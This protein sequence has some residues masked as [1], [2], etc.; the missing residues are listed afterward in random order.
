MARNYRAGLEDVLPAVR[1]IAVVYRAVQ[2]EGKRLC[3]I[4]ERKVAR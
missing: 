4:L 1:G 3:E 2:S